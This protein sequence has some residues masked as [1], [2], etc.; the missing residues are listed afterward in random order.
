MANII[1]IKRGA[2]VPTTN[3][4]LAPGEIGF[5]TTDDSLYM[6]KGTDTTPD[7]VRVGED[8]DSI[9]TKIKTVDGD[10]SGL[11]A[12][13]LDGKHASDFS[14]DGHT[15]TL[16]DVTDSSSIMLSKTITWSS[17]D[18]IWHEKPPGIYYAGGN[19]ATLGYPENYSM[20]IHSTSPSSPLVVQICYGNTKI[21]VR[22]FSE[23]QPMAW[24]AWENL[25]TP[26]WANILS[27]P[28]TATRWPTWAEVTGKPSTFAPSSHSHTGTTTTGTSTQHTTAHGYI[29]LG[30]MNTGYA[31]IYSD[32]G[33]FYMNQD[34][35][36]ASGKQVW[37]SG[38]S[39][40][41]N[42]SSGYIRFQNGLKLNWVKVT[43][44]ANT[45]SKAF[46]WASAFTSTPYATWSAG[47]WYDTI[48]TVDPVSRTGGT[49]EAGLS[50]N[51][52][53]IP[54]TATF[55]VFAIGV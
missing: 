9:L 35:Q 49:L 12:D 26:T 53:V 44:S 30:P 27:K 45:R 37:H 14:L 42:A 25:L 1:K 39:Y 20:V 3:A 50:T 54:R 41:S 6:N 33:P 21:S 24:S 40:G 22:R 28:T 11:D 46:T 7:I 19:G 47:I 51:V 23:S 36:V 2:V 8:A 31:H 55:T 10:S 32:R 52:A 15:H 38:N 34:L 4:Q 48:S 29:Q 16:T 18:R 43:I 13:L 17:D 5:N